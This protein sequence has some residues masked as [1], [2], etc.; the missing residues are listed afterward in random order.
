MVIAQGDIWWANLGDPI[1]AQPGYRRPMV[2]VQGNAF[3]Q[4]RIATVVCVPLTTNL[5]W[6]EAPGN[7]MLRRSITGLAQDSVANV[8]QIMVLD[9]MQ[10][11]ERIGATP[12][13]QFE[14]ILAGV[15]MV[16]GR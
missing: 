10:L 3:N 15:D 7:V 8:S 14:T 5:K 6:A 2:I 16:L 12:S 1:G 13:R 4:S 11:E 9:K